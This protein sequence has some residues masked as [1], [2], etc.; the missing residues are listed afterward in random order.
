MVVGGH[1]PLVLRLLACG[2]WTKW[3][4]CQPGRRYMVPVRVRAATQ[5]EAEALVRQF[6]PDATLEPVD[7]PKRPRGR[8]PRTDGSQASGRGETPTVGLGAHG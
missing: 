5:G 1:S 8:P 2:L 4:L 6:L 3:R 7:M